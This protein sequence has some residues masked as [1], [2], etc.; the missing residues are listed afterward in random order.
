MNLDSFVRA[1]R[2]ANRRAK[3]LDFFS[4]KWF[5][6]FVPE[7]IGEPLWDWAFDRYARA[8]AE[9]NLWMEAEIRRNGGTVFRLW[10]VHRDRDFS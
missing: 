1:K 8:D 10:N 7:A 2:I 9:A 3:V 5:A 4:S 6:L